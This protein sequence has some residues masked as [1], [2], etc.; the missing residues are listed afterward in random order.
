MTAWWRR[1][2]GPT[3]EEPTA[4][5]VPAVWQRYVARAR[6]AGVDRVYL[7][8]TFDCDTDLDIDVAADLDRQLRA[9]GVKA[10][11]AVPGAQ[12]RKRPETWRG[13]AQA[14]AEFLNHGDRAHA[15]F[16][17]GRYWPVTFYDQLGTED[18]ISD[19]Q[20]ADRAIR[21]L[22]GAAP[23]G[24]RAPHFGSFQ[25]PEQLDLIYRTVLPMGYRY[26]STT[27]P[28]LALERGPVVAAGNMIEL[29][30][31]GSYRN[32]TTLLD[33]WTYL[34]DRVHYTLGDDYAD[35]FI[36]TIERMTAERFPA[37]LTYYGDP[38]HVAGQRPFARVLDAIA[39]AG[40]PSLHGR[41][42][43]R[44]FRPV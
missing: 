23:V 12:L 35:L 37:I 20:A 13:L 27:T 2:L 42:A 28:A 32:P 22:T 30:T 43:A 4:T 9:H 39:R 7:L 40:I 10:G 14:G 41:D 31:L 19:I 5:E 8:L 18:V 21:E 1:W 3:V 15:E 6:A 36:E 29:P 25:A 44:L 38:S 17:D 16:R 24:F 11:Y 26:C 33:S 34:T